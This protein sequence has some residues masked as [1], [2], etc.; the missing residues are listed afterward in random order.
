M[1]SHENNQELSSFPPQAKH[2]KV[3]KP[4]VVELSDSKSS[5]LLVNNTELHPELPEVTSS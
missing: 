3:I 4:Q 5:V 2:N 1:G